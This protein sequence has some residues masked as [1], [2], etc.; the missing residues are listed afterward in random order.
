MDEWFDTIFTTETLVTIALVIGA[1]VIGRLTAGPKD[2]QNGVNYVGSTGHKVSAEAWQM[3]DAELAAGRLIGAIKIY[4]EN[5]G[6]G[7]KDAKE[8]VERRRAEM[9]FPHRSPGA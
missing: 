4:R 9:N 7:L 6:A 8:A 3:V 5:T 1:F 2:R